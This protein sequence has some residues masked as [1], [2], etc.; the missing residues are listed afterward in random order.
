MWINA[1][2]KRVPKFIVLPPV[3]FYFESSLAVQKCDLSNAACLCS[4]QPEYRKLGT[5]GWL[6][7][8]LFNRLLG[9]IEEELQV[10][11]GSIGSCHQVDA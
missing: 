11:Q 2:L 10:L 9:G 8:N 1:L 7:K 4:T 6:N 5:S 3:P